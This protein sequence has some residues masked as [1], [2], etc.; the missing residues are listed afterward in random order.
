[1][2][3]AQPTQRSRLLSLLFPTTFR[4]R[5]AVNVSLR[6]CAS[7]PLIETEEPLFSWKGVSQFDSPGA[8]QPLTTLG[9]RRNGEIA[10]DR[11]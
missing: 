6:G 3:K 4:L 5:E 10:I 8:G 9:G 1:M 2:Y 11:I 7:S